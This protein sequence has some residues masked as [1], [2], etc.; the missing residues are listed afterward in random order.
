MAAEGF[1][2]ARL[3]ALY[4][5]FDPDRS[6]LAVYMGMA[7]EF[8]ARTVLD[9][10]CGTGTFATVLACL[11]Y[12]VTGLDP[13]K[14][15]LDIARAKPYADR[16]TWIHGTVADLPCDL[17]VDLVTMTANVAQFFVA[18]D[19][20]AAVL[21]AVHDVL[22]P[23]GRLVFE[24]RDPARKGWEAWTRDNTYSRI[25]VPGA[26]DLQTWLDVTKV[27]GELV[28]FED[29]TVFESDGAILTSTATLR[30]RSKNAVVSSLQAAGLTVDDVRDAPDRPG[31]E[32]I[33]V[34]RRS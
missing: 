14:A 19:E 9:I 24:T 7:A 26:G 30:F 11:G 1:E 10:G 21:K 3:A 18:D 13:A 5:P 22:R 20:W 8:R 34:A 23:G 31:H 6:D 2:N 27:D 29:T 25:T 4:D 33:F 32:F 17:R 12:E 16:V 28:T 15:S